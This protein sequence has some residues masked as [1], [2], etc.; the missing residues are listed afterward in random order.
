MRSVLD[1]GSTSLQLQCQWA[2]ASMA[3]PALLKARWR[4][5]LC[6]QDSPS[7]CVT[8]NTPPPPTH[9]HTPQKRKE[10]RNIKNLS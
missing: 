8:L 6:V 9:T 7:T 3:S 1:K 2:L 4:V 5:R 10:K